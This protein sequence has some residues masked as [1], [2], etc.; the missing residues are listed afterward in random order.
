MRHIFTRNLLKRYPVITR[1]EGSYLFDEGDRAILDGCSGAVVVNL[2]HGHPEVMAA[3]ET[4]A[5][6]VTF[7]H[8][9]LFV[10]DALAEASEALAGVLPPELGTIYFVNSG[11]EATETA[12]KLAHAYWRAAG[13]PEK[14]LVVARWDSYHGNTLGALSASGHRARRAPYAE[15]LLPF[16]HFDAPNLYRRPQGTDPCAYGRERAERLAEALE[17]VGPE[18]VAVVMVEPV[19]GSSLAAMPP[20]EG[21]LARLAEICRTYDVLLAVDEVMCGAGRTGRWFA[22]QHAGITP[23]LVC[24]GKGVSNGVTPVAGVAAHGRLVEAIRAVGGGFVHGHTFGGNPLGM[25]VVRAVVEVM[26]R[27]RLVEAVVPRGQALRERLVGLAEE[28]SVIGDVRGAGL[29]LGVELVADPATRRPFAPEANVTGRLSD[30]LIEEG[31]A[32][33]PCPGIADGRAGDGFIVAPPYTATDEDFDRL[34]DSF[35]RALK[36]LVPTLKAG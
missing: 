23:D 20:P 10:T 8:T 18:R 17:A 9:S 35:R 26:V 25:A 36:R 15:L 14:H 4:Q 22:F 3:L 2:G 11:S 30:L 33:Y 28:F 29:L 13:R 19:V 21:Y 24:F 1:A 31:L 5:R 7:V 32:L 34:A 12:I 27:E 16:P 6:R